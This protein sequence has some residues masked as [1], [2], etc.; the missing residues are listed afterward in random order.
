MSGGL[1]ENSDSLE[2]QALIAATRTSGRTSPPVKP[3]LDILA[4]RI[5][6]YP[7]VLTRLQQ[8]EALYRSAIGLSTGKS[9]RGEGELANDL[10]AP[11][12][13]AGDGARIRVDPEHPL[14]LLAVLFV[15]GEVEDL[16]YPSDNEDLVL[17]LYLSQRVA[18]EI[19]EGNLTRCQRASKG[20]EQSPTRRR[21]EVVDGGVVRLLLFR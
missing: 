1:F 17:R 10:D 16:L 21:D 19:L 6:I 4:R 3:G 13:G 9:C 20:A 14:Y 7:S 8:P 5:S 11:L 18:V 15:G 12:D 2:S